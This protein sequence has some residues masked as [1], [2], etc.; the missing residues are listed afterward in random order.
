MV[1]TGYSN[2]QIYNSKIE[3]EIFT[4]YDKDSVNYNFL[5]SICAIDSTFSENDYVSYKNQLDAII[6]NFSPKELKNSKEKKRIKKIYS[7]IH[8]KF[9]KKYELKAIFTDIFK[10]GNYN[11]VSASALY[12]YVFDKMEIPYYIKEMP[13][14]VYLIAYPKTMKIHVETTAPGEYGLYIPSDSEIKKIVDE[15]VT[16]K[17]VTRQEVQSKG[18]GQIYQD[19]YY[20]KKFVDKRSLIGMQYFNLVFTNIEKKK[21]KVAYDNIS[22]SLKFY[23]SPF[24]KEISKELMLS[25]LSELNINND[26]ELEFLFSGLDQL[27]FK[28]DISP[29]SVMYLLGKIENNNHKDFIE[30]AAIKFSEL[31]DTLLIEFCQKELYEYLAQSE[32]QKRNFDDALRFA[33]KFIEFE[34]D[35]KVA[36]EVIIYSIYGKFSLMTY[37]E[38]TVSKFIKYQQK[39]PFIRGDKRIETLISSMYGQ[40]VLKYFLE[41]NSHKGLEYLSFFEDT[42]DT[43]AENVQIVPGMIANIY[44]IVGR[45]YYGQNKYKEAKRHFEKGVKYVPANT[46][47]SKMLK[48]TNE[49]LN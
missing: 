12:A 14:H 26:E 4:D 29:N 10:K 45:F 46:E 2:A 48:W 9:L 41:R 30:S 31:K 7:T 20:G 40:L 25:N 43:Q 49:D 42:M 39:F 44:L 23:N 1:F 21:F 35:S 27:K 13:S 18:Y 16:F 6:A 11:C 24:S 38:E 37:S 15:L 19:H 17:L 47:L 8:N 32:A 33:D 22:K 28:K 36:M 3:K 5:K 34:S